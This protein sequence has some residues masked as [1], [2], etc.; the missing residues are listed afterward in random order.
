M[1]KG[2]LVRKAGYHGTAMLDMAFSDE[3]ES[4]V[5][6]ELKKMYEFTKKRA[7]ELQVYF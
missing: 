1:G 5:C 2:E 4:D 7:G 3:R 6:E